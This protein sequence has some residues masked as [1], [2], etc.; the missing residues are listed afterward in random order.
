MKDSF[1]YSGVDNYSNPFSGVNAV[2]LDTN[3]ILEYWCNPFRYELYSGIKEEDIYRDPNNIVLMGGRSTGKS[4][5]LRY[6]SYP[7]QLKI[8]EKENSTFKEISL[9]NQG[10]GYYFRIDGAKLKSF[11]GHGLSQEHWSSVFT[12]Y[13]ELI[14]GR[15]YIEV[16]KLLEDEQSIE[17]ET[18]NLNLIPQFCDLLVCNT[19]STLEGIIVEFD[20]RIKEVELF[21]GNVPFYKKEF[22]PKIRGFLSQYLS[23]GI[24]GIIVNVIPAFKEINHVILLDEYENFL[25]F[26]QKI[27]NTLLRFSK[28]HIKFRI[29]MRLEGFRTFEMISEDDFIKEGR[30]YRKVVF[31]EVITKNTGYQDFLCEISKKRL[32]SIPVFRNKKFTDIKL[33]LGDNEDLEEEAHDLTSTKPDKIFDFFSKKIPESDLSIV[34]NKEYP[35]LELLNF[36]WLSRGVPPEKTLES[37]NGYLQK[38]KNSADAEKYRRDYIDKYKLTLTFLLCSIYKKN[39]QYYSFNTFSFLSSGIVGH[40]IEL[41]RRSFAVAEFRDNETLLNKGIIRKDFQHKAAT[42]FSHSEKQQ[43]GRIETYGGTISKF[44]E[45]IGNIFRGFHL[46]FQMRYPETNQFAIN[47]DSIDNMD[48]KDSMKAAIRWSIIQKK[49]KMQRS[50]PSESLKDIYT[51]NRIFSPS[52]QISYRTRGGK[53]VLLNESILKNLTSDFKINLNDFIPVDDL[54]LK[55]ETDKPNLFSNHEF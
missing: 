29:G 24:P 26:Q 52:F 30:E 45:N 3:L 42:E 6:W 53:S 13:F 15:Q 36:I 28:P 12:H 34:R 1:S 48:I 4:M 50:G 11:Q 9:K 49:P 25:P 40:F 41:C 8:A 46:D 38:Q 23:F 16:L 55:D 21:L 19:P 32:E 14:I 20:I 37:M 35:L 18:I 44:I 51:I 54:K 31:E 43:I 5:F 27:V 33:I 39:K 47:I 7:V 17:K 22:V 2:Q 10:I